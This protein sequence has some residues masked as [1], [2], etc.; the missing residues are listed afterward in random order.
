MLPGSKFFFTYGVN[1][2]FI[3]DII[4]SCLVV[5][6]AF[7]HDCTNVHGTTLIKPRKS[8]PGQDMKAHVFFLAKSCAIF[9][10]N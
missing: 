4:F 3:K 9:A 5:N 10:K 6:D 2:V 7:E 1:F 8:F